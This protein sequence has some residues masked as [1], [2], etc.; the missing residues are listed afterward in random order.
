MRFAIWYRCRPIFVV[1]LPSTRA[2]AAT[3]KPVHLKK[4]QFMSPWNMKNSCRKLE[5]FGNDQIL[6]T[7]RGTFSVTI[8][9]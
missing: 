2:A 3:A 9:L 8:C 5:S 1:R 6:L 7:D 4:G